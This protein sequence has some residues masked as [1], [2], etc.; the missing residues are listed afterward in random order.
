MNPH[1]MAAYIKGWEYIIAIIFNMAF[2]A[3]WALVRRQPA[4]E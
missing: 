1:D 3:F 2:L 4:R